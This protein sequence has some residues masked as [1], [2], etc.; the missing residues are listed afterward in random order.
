MR[1]GVRFATQEGLKDAMKI[2]DYMSQ[3]VVTA[4]LRDGLHQ[5]FHRM[6]EYN[7]RHMPVL[8]EREQLM[9]IISERDIR[10]PDTVDSPNISRYYALDNSMRVEDAMSTRPCTV[11]A[12]D[13][14]RV[15]LDEL[16]SKKYGAIPVV[17]DT[18]KL[19]GILSAIDVLRAFKDSLAA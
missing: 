7:V 16:I 15:A 3:D 4:N 13:P 10:R 19:V 14:I 9:N 18:G 8:G 12:D 6:M 2:S 11:K 5:T 17:D 1:W